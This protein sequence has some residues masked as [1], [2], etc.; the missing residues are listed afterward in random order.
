MIMDAKWRFHV[1][2]AANPPTIANETLPTATTTEYLT[3][4]IDLT[5][6]GYADGGG[7]LFIRT[8]VVA[9]TAGA[10]TGFTIALKDCA[11]VGGSYTTIAS[12]STKTDRSDLVAGQELQ[13][14]ALP[15]GL[16]RFVKISFTGTAGTTGATSFTSGV[17]TS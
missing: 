17:T 15:L 2:G 10:G 6:A 3:D 5:A 14:I 1:T 12:I 11:T 7:E 8:K 13:P 9:S 4:P 16:K